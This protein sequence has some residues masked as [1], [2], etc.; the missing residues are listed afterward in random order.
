MKQS[1]ERQEIVVLDNMDKFVDGAAVRRV[2]EI[3]F[4]ICNQVIDEYVLV[5]EGK[6][7]T[8]ILE[9]YNENAIVAE[10]AGALPIAA[11]DAYSERIIGK[12]V[13]CIV[14]GGNND[15][16][17]MQ[18]I[19]E[20]SLIYEGMKHYFTINFLNGP[21]L[22]GNFWMRFSDRRTILRGSNIPKKNSRENGPALVGIELKHKD[23]YEP[24]IDRMVKKGVQFAEINKDPYLFHL[25]I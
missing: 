9:L 21:E 3:T 22:Y 6:V 2:G 17:R 23:D 16:E 19:K 1:S 4:D 14:S 18:E 15:I 11:L 13:V 24:L 7:C 25:L 10:P 12:N 8:S 20:R 5:P